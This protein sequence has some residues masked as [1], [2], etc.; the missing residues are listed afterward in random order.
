[1]TESRLQ[2]LILGFLRGRGAYAIKMKPQPG[3]PVGCPDIFAFYKER[4]VAVEVKKSV[5]APFRVGQEPT[6]AYLHGFNPFVFVVFPE[7][8]DEVK[9]LLSCEFFR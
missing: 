4:W 1:M 2:Q 6:L 8:W 9:E 7:N 5:T 3:V